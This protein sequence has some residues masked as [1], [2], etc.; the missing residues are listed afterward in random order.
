MERLESVGER[1]LGGEDRVGR[2]DDDVGQHACHTVPDQLRGEQGKDGD[3][4]V[5]LVV[6]EQVLHRDDL[7]L[8]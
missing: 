7:D 1:D 3:S 8:K 5:H 2:L 6:V 4:G